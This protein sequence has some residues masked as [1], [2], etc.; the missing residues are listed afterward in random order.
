MTPAY[1]VKRIF[2]TISHVINPVFYVPLGYY[3]YQHFRNKKIV[4]RTSALKK[5][6]SFLEA[7]HKASVVVVIEHFRNVIE[8]KSEK[9]L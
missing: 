5:M 2:I 7:L 9:Y 6:P 3:I 8:I 4:L 1:I